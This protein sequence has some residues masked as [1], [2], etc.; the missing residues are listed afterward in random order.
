[1]KKPRTKKGATPL[2]VDIPVV[3][4][5]PSVRAS[6]PVEVAVAEPE[7]RT[8]KRVAVSKKS[9]EDPIPS[10]TS[11]ESNL[12]PY[13]LFF[14][15][16]RYKIAIANPGWKTQQ[17]TTEIGRLWSEQKK[18]VESVTAPVPAQAPVPV[19]V[20]V[21]V[22]VPVSV[23]VPATQQVVEENTVDVRNEEDDKKQPLHVRRKKIPKSIRT[24]IWNKYIGSDITAAKCCCCREEKITLNN[25]HC[26][27][28][29]AETKGGD[30]TINNLRPICAP[31]N[32]S[33]GTKS[34]NDFTEE[35][36]GWSI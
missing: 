13:H 17:I 28:V 22:S 35:Y 2:L 36:F 25:W 31:C 3:E 16:N 11:E 5:T 34:M 7:V 1:V 15:D 32:S 12:S 21:P 10:P 20:P 33:M 23:P 30:T 8:K 27:H 18:Q 9:K 29:V 19:P 4:E 26:G 24:L 6:S 14:K